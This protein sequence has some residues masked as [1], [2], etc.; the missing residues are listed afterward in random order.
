MAGKKDYSVVSVTNGLTKN[1]ASKLLSA[2]SNAKNNVAPLSR[3]TAAI[4]TKEGIGAL[5]QKGIRQLI[6]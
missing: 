3:S 6:G 2:I 5:L 1:Q 4:T